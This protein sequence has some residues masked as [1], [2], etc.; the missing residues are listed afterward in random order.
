MTRVGV[1]WGWT[2]PD[3]AMAC[4]DARMWERDEVPALMKASVIMRWPSWISE[5]AA[6]QQREAVGIGE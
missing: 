3:G 1:G 4:S 6:E 2:F 5:E